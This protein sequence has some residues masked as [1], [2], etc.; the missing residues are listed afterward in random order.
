LHD[1]LPLTWIL[2]I[3][4]QKVFSFPRAGVG[5]Q[6]GRASVQLHKK[7]QDAGASIMGS[8]AGAWEPEKSAYMAV[9]TCISFV[10]AASF[11]ETTRVLTEASV[12]GSLDDLRGLKENVIVGRLMATGWEGDS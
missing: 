7:Y 6:S 10:S 11:Q 12:N 8:H 4:V 2:K 1:K 9:N 5:M 3:I